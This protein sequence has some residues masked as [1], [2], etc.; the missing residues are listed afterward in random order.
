M[1][2]LPQKCQPQP[3]AE[4]AAAK[5]P[6][7]SS[8]AWL[9]RLSVA[10]VASACV[11]GAAVGLYGTHNPAFHHEGAR[12]LQEI[13]TA[14]GIQITFIPKKDSPSAPSGLRVD[15]YLFPQPSADGRLHFDGRL[16]Y[17][18]VDRE[19]NFTLIDHKG[20][21]TVED[22]KTHKLIRNDCLI[23][24]NIPPV[25]ELV[26]AINDARVVD[27]VSGFDIQC[28]NNSKMV[29]FFFAGEPYVFCSKPGA[30]L[31]K[32]HGEDL[33][34]SIQV[35]Q[36]VASG[37]PTKESLV[38]P[39]G[40]D[41][42]EC[43]V[44]VDDVAPT[45]APARQLL[46][47]KLST[48]VQHTHD[49]LQ[50]AT[51]GSR[52]GLLGSNECGCTDG[53]KTCLFVHGLGESLDA[54]AAD[55]FPSYWGSIEQHA[56]CC[57]SYKFM[58][59]DTTNNAWYDD[60]LPKKVCDTALSMVPGTKNPMQMDNIVIVGH[61]M[62]NLIFSA[63]I[64][65][66]FCGINPQTS[67]WIALA[68]PIEGSKSSSEAVGIC[69]LRG[70]GGLNGMLESAL[71]TFGFCPSK[72]SMMSLTYRDSPETNAELRALYDQATETYH[73]H[74]TSNLCG[75]NPVGLVTL[76]SAMYVALSMFSHHQTKQNDGAVDFGSCRAG[77]DI[78][79]YDKSWRTTRFYMSAINHGDASFSHG[80]G[81]WGED[82][83]PIRWFQCQF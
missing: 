80:D 81:L 9:K 79:K 15:G 67:K 51:G 4:A 12:F 62:G 43:D 63:A 47:R 74:V 7:S 78:N 46:T 44:L 37:F 33:E 77:L 35:F 30:A 75:V 26:D 23:K 38:R 22:L 39:D 28:T 60:T 45:P 56:P 82:R 57:S 83:K 14:K 16:T 6:S 48:A 24:D 27:D 5:A 69:K 32:V 49:V 61:S 64:M 59:M 19:Y 40:K 36:D 53:L 29:E 1:S 13:A 55:A 72:A 21:V 25:S 3:A 41:L 17:T 31:G 50:V 70:T 20:Y 11:A 8:A 18:H 54:P 2:E 76:R 65:K 66:N 58:R 42:G 10:A 34:A 73:R 71:E 68:G 52:R